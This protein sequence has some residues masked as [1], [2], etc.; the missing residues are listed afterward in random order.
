VNRTILVVMVGLAAVLAAIGVLGGEDEEPAPAPPA[1]TPTVARI[2]RD[3]ERVR[4]LEFER[5]PSVRRVSG[6]QARADGLRELDRQVPAAERRAEERLLTLLGLLPPGSDLRELLGTALSSEVGGYYLPRSDT[7]AIVDGAGLGSL[8]DRITLAHELTHALEDQHFGI[9]TDGGTGFRRDRAL[10]DGALREGTATLAMV[11]YVV[12]EETGRADIPARLRARVLKELAGVAVPASSGLPRYVREG[13][14][15][16]Y[17]AGARLVDG[18]QRRGGWEAVNRAF[19][20]DAPVS[21]EQVMHPAK[22]EAREAPLRVRVTERALGG[23]LPAAAQAVEQGDFGEF[24]TEQLLR[25]ANGRE[26]SRRAAAGWGGGAFALW[27]L[28]GERWVLVM[29]WVWDSEG[30]ASEFE[31]AA[32]RTA[33][34]LGGASAR[35]GRTTA[36]AMAPRGAAALAK[37]AAR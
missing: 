20:A 24:D 2:A 15:F 3:V 1:D 13:M 32:R 27:R 35:S 26:R 21:S 34:A 37:R 18:I 23:A 28:P 5:L 25:E 31:A 10:A 30:D 29:R 11:E 14:V 19:G 17:A 12:L 8:E 33:Q 7:L 36:L 22:Y 16:P 9:E 4:E 6:G